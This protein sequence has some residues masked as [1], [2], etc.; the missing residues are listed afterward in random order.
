MC[1]RYTRMKFSIYHCSESG[2]FEY[3]GRGRFDKSL[4][5]SSPRYSKPTHNSVLNLAG[6]VTAIT[7]GDGELTAL[8]F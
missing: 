6:P 7:Y 1:I 5:V 4:V 3:Q 8:G 2:D